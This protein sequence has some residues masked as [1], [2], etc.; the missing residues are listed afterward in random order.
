[1]AD[2]TTARLFGRIIE[3]SLQ[4]M[5]ET[6]ERAKFIDAVWRESKDFDF[7]PYQ[8][9]NNAALDELERLGLIHPRS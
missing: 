2:R 7:A 4:H 5:E 3:L 1:M 6:S 8:M 9:G